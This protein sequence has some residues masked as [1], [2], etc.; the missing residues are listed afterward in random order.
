MNAPRDADGAALVPAGGEAALAGESAPRDASDA[1]V[2]L[3]CAVAWASGCSQK[4]ILSK[5]AAKVVHL[6]ADLMDTDQRLAIV[7]AYHVSKEHAKHTGKESTFLPL[8]R[9]RT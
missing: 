5:C 9:K 6:W 4:R 7:K 1:D 8:S 3:A 2:E